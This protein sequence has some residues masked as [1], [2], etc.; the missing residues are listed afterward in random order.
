MQMAEM[1]IADLGGIKLHYDDVGE[2]PALILIHGSGPGASGRA[3]FIRNIEA[4]SKDFRVIVPDLPGF[5]QSDMK[6]A[7]TPIPGW[8]ADKIVEL[9]DHLDIA[10]AHFVGNSLGGAITLKIAME[11]PSRVDRMILMGPGGGTPVTSVFP[12]E[13]IKTL[14]S[15]YDGPGP[16]LERLKAFINQFVYDPS[17]ITEELL[18]ERLKAA[19]DPRVIAQPP[20]RLGPGVA[21]EELWRD[22]RMAKLPHETLIIWGREDRVM[23]LDTG[24]V[25][26]KQIPRARLLVM[27]QCGH[28]AQWEH[29]DE[30]NKTVLGFLKND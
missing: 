16:S 13:G 21:F 29:A 15:F 19:M 7:G 11:S 20:M 12:T 27:P 6:P 1:K 5:G 4:L 14:V 23:P 28:W 25:L 24:F 30:F 8:W 9:L 2:G 3:N 22:P 26:M 18:A 17:Q 10:K